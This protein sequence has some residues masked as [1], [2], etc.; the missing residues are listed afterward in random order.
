MREDHYN[1]KTFNEA[2][3]GFKASENDVFDL[4]LYYINSP[5]DTPGNLTYTLFI[6]DFKDKF[7]LKYPRNAYK[8][9][10]DG[11]LHLK[12]KT[13]D[14]WSSDGKDCKSYTLF[15]SM[16]WDEGKGMVTVKLGEDTKE[17]FLKK[18]SSMEDYEI[19]YTLSMN[20]KY[21][22]RLYVLFKEWVKN[23]KK[24]YY[25]G[26]D[27]L[28]N[29]LQVPS[30]YSYGNIKKEILHT[31]LAEINDNTDLIVSY[32]EHLRSVRGGNKVVG[33]TFKI[34]KKTGL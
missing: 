31:A 24:E 13:I 17:L 2:R 8:R 25:S 16:E 11:L 14:I 27:E 10:H 28:R 21:S 1:P 3:S 30:S 32:K 12:G 23:K 9:V 15:Q 29:K 6:A 18:R 4:L 5:D 26:L 7:G 33:L 34:K 22:K 19:C 20:S